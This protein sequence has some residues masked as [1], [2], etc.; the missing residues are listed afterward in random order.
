MANETPVQAA[1]AS[2][3]AAAKSKLATLVAAAKPYAIG[4]VGGAIL[5]LVLKHF[6]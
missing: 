6:L 4:G 2:V 1:V 3:E 5:A